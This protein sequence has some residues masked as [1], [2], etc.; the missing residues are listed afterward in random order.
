MSAAT[1]Y[2]QLSLSEGFP[3]ALCEAM[4]CGCIPIVSDVSS[5]PGIVADKGLVVKHR[6]VDDVVAVLEQALL[7][8]ATG[9]DQRS[10]EARVRIV[11]HFTSVKRLEA[12]RAAITSMH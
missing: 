4:L 7:I 2:L 1:F 5:M 11:D 6:R 10:T 8:G 3:N 9:R 12:I